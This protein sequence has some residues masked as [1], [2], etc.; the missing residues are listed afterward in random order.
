MKIFPE[1]Q[2]I[3]NL[4]RVKFGIDPTFYRLHIG[5]LVPLVWLKKNFKK[6]ITI[7][8]GTITARLGDPSGQD[9]TRPILSEVEVQANTKAISQQIYKILPSVRI[10]KQESILAGQLLEISS[11]FTVSKM[12]SRDNFQAREGVSLHE[13]SVPILQAMDSVLLQTELELGGDDQLF[14]FELTREVQKIHNQKPEACLMFPII[15]GTDGQKMSK[16]KNNCIWLDD[17]Q[18]EQRILSISDEVMDEWFPLF[19]D[20]EPEIHP[21]ERKKQLAKSIKDLI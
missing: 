6:D 11:H 13:L 21:F 5:H 17:P 1:H 18:I 9:K 8:L 20:E 2:D 16:S 12:M 10:W 19:C 7:V 3:K 4:N 14:N 15:K